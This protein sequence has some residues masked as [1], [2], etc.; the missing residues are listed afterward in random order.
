MNYFLSSFSAVNYSVIQ[1]QLA[2]TRQ[3]QR[4]KEV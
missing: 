2:D 3:K 1:A 4:L